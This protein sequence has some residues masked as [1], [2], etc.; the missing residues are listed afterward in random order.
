MISILLFATDLSQAFFAMQEPH[1]IYYLIGF[2]PIP[3]AFFRSRPVTFR[4]LCMIPRSAS[5]IR[6]TFNRN[7]DCGTLDEL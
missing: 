1:G 2:S 4:P 7:L 3:R 6:T 5:S